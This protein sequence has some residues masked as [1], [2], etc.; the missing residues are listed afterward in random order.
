MFDRRL[1]LKTISAALL[2]VSP[3][4]ACSGEGQDYPLQTVPLTNT[5]LRNQTFSEFISWYVGHTDW[6]FDEGQDIGAKI[7]PTKG[8]VKGTYILEDSSWAPVITLPEYRGNMACTVL[9]VIQE[10]RLPVV[11]N[12]Q[13]IAGMMP[14]PDRITPEIQAVIKS[15]A[16]KCK[17][18]IWY[19]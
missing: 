19:E 4:L 14:P 18:N 3:S 5:P 10:R 8:N 9:D 7:P 6:I 16:I 11:N 17:E 2:P 13:S 15:Q 12:F 1:F